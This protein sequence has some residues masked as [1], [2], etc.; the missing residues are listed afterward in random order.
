MLS[1]LVATPPSLNLRTRNVL[2]KPAL[3]QITTFSNVRDFPSRGD[4]ESRG[5]E[6]Q[7]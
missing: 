7:D 4:V 5:I 2:P 6:C 3:D 1:I